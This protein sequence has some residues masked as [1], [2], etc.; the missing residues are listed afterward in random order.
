MY[1]DSE[2]T[3]IRHLIL[4]GKVDEAR[5][6][7]ISTLT[8]NPY[9]DQAW[10]LA[11]Q[12]TSNIDQRKIFIK[13]VF[14][15]SDVMELA[16][17]GFQNFGKLEMGTEREIS[18]PPIE[19]LAMQNHQR[20]LLDELVNVA[21]NPPVPAPPPARRMKT[22]VVSES[23]KNTVESNVPH[24]T[25]EE[26]QN[27]VQTERSSKNINAS[28]I[29]ES[30]I[31]LFSMKAIGKWIMVGAGLLFIVIIY[32]EPF[33]QFFVYNQISPLYCCFIPLFLIGAVVT[34]VGYLTDKNKR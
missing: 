6:E 1:I 8:K 3:H 15:C 26:N 10:T 21:L 14:D 28:H 34:I 16:D 12:L 30:T 11:A 20:I 27:K 9:D 5:S 32:S 19:Y 13:R 29:E 18:V 25:L 31:Q 17:W 22:Q 24:I 33:M 4:S 7:L 23:A 2:V